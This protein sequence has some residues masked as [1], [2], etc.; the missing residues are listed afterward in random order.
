MN[1]KYV[2]LLSIIAASVVISL[3]S[4]IFINR[5]TSA[6][7]PEIPQ[8]NTIIDNGPNA[9]NMVFLADKE[10]AEEYTNYFLSISPYKENKDKFNFYYVNEKAECEIYKGIA[11]LCHNKD[12]IKKAA[13]C[14]N[15]YIIVVQSKA[16]AIRSSSFSGT[17]SINRAHP[18]T[19]LAHE[20]GHALANLAEEYG[21][22][23]RI[24][25][26]S[27]NCISA[28]PFKEQSDGCYVECTDSGHFR[29]IDDGFMRTLSASSYG[30]FDENLIIKKINEQTTKKSSSIL[31]GL[32][33]NDALNSPETNQDCA[34]QSYILIEGKYQNGEAQIL[35]KEKFTGCANSG[36]NNG[37]LTYK[38]VSDNQETIDEK[39]LQEEYIFMDDDTTQDPNLNG[40]ITQSPAE[41]DR[42][43]IITIPSRDETSSLEIL[44]QNGNLIS[45]NNLKDVGARPCRI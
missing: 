34:Q 10:T 40:L 32:A 8:C 5:S 25:F 41:N 20:I 37:I 2:V 7:P 26:G 42:N 24:P 19:V 27:E 12:V 36:T 9:I 38:T 6:S 33:V 21:T 30:I 11:L 28:C 3:L 45:Q 16:N 31:S 39:T 13:A 44:D 29:S 35:S 17:L 18:F 43:F 23:A 4:L 15:D 14:P 22:T 1:K